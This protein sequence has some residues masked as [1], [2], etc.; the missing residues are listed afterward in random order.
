MLELGGR[1]VVRLTLG[2]ILE[3]DRFQLLW[4]EVKEEL[5]GKPLP[6]GLRRMIS[7]PL[8]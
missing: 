2:G 5:A 1:V 8:V 3:L 4:V 6:S 7:E